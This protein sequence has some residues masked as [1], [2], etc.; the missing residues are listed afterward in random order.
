M[1]DLNTSIAITYDRENRGI[2]RLMARYIITL[3]PPITSMSVVHDN[4]CGPLVVTSE[5]LSKL[6]DVNPP[7]ILATD[8][9]AAMIN[10]SEDLIKANKWTT[11]TAAVMDSGKLSFGDDT[12]THSFTNFLVP[13]QPSAASEIYRTLKSNG[14]AIFTGW[15]FHGFVDLMRRCTKVILPSAGAAGPPLLAEDVLRSQFEKAGFGTKDT[16]LQSHVEYL[17]FETLDELN[18]LA[19]GPFGKFFTKDWG[20]E[21]IGRLPSVISEVLTPEEVNRN[22]LEMIAWIV[23]AKKE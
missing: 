21:Q 17:Q 6:S 12:F 9:S 22:G 5:I 15:K 16:E 19:E 18:S 1:D 3:T 7:K 20:P 8:N 14:T 13:P 23:I 11:V 4:A 2:P 10:V